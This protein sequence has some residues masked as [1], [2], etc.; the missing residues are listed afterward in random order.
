M[1]RA[2]AKNK[3]KRKPTTYSHLRMPKET[4][5]YLPKLQAVKNIISNPEELGFP[6]EDIPDQP[7][8]LAQEELAVMA[9]HDARGIL[10]AVLEHRQ[11]IVEP[12]IDWRMTDDTDETAHD[13]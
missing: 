3:A 2:I 10:S 1:A 8:L 9:R 6:L 13:R 7:V 5:N 11:R 4:R 12:L